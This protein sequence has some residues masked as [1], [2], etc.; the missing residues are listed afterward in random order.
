MEIKTKFAPHDKV[1]FMESNKPQKGEVLNVSVAVT[2]H[3]EYQST[4][5]TVEYL[6]KREAM[7]RP[8]SVLF[9]SKESLLASL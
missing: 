2:L 7:L 1:W 5:V 3:G 9:D 8:E 6:L 4:Y